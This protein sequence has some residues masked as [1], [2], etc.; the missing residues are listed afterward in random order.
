MTGENFKVFAASAIGLGSP[1][2]N[3]F[4]NNLEPAL[5]D[6]LL[7]GQAGVAFVTVLY[8]IQKIRRKKDDDV[9]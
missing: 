6:L 2:M 8:I 5:R 3:V 9:V 4:F 1:A 7:L